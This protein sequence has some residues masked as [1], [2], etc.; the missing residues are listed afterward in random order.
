MKEKEDKRLSRGARV[1]TRLSAHETDSPPS[2]LASCST[3]DEDDEEEEEE[4][5]AI[6]FTPSKGRVTPRKPNNFTKV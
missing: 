4:N 3:E 6:I 5:P 2:T 1:R